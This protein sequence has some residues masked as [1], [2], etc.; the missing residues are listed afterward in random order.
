MAAPPPPVLGA[1]GLVLASHLG[2]PTKLSTCLDYYADGTKDKYDRQYT[3]VMTVFMSVPG[4]PAPAQIHKL[5][6]NNPRES[7]L[8]FATLVLPTNNPAHQGLLYALHSL[9]SFAP[10]LGHPPTQW[11]DHL[12]GSINEAIS[13]QIPTMV[14]FPADAFS[15]LNGG[16]LYRVRL[17]QRIDAM[18]AADPDLQHLGEFASQDAGIKLIQSRT[19]VPISHCYLRHFISEPLTPCQDWEIAVHDITHHNNQVTCALLIGFI[20]LACT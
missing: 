19:M 5:I 4:G 12:L 20:C 10:R 13:N 11:D 7:S 9:S 18:L 15:Q 6:S 3:N 2:A 16:A 8:W 14:E 17:P 1:G